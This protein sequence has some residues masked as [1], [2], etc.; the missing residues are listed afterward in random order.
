MLGISNLQ[1]DLSTSGRGTYQLL[2][3]RLYSTQDGIEHSHHLIHHCYH[4]LP[5]TTILLLLPSV[6]SPKSLIPSYQPLS[7]LIIDI[8]QM[9]IPPFRNSLITYPFPRLFYHWVKSGILDELLCRAKSFYVFNFSQK[10][11][12]IFLESP[13]IWLSSSFS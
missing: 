12:T 6:I 3:K 11:L 13:L 5:M 10:R 2:P 1:R 7:H 4:S 8:S 9:T